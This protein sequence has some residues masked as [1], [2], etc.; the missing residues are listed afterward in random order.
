MNKVFLFKLI[1]S[2]CL[3]IINMIITGFLLCTGEIFHALR[4]IMT[5][6]DETRQCIS[7]VNEISKKKIGGIFVSDTGGWGRLR[8][9]AHL[10]ESR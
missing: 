1:S 8:D 4:S 10:A 9:Y 5:N 3:Y 7:R 6:T 2:A